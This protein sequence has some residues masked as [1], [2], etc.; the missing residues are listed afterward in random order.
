[1][2]VKEC[3]EAVKF[4]LPRGSVIEYSLLKCSFSP[5]LSFSGLN[6]E[7]KQVKSVKRSRRRRALAS[8]SLER[9][10]ILRNHENRIGCNSPKLKGPEN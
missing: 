3:L 5:N 8:D 6:E 2:Y 1:M 4:H 7:L 10:K 9:N